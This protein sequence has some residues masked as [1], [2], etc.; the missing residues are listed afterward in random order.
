MFL[1]CVIPYHINPTKYHFKS[2]ASIVVPTYVILMIVLI[3][4]LCLLKQDCG[5]TKA[6]LYLTRAFHPYHPGVRMAWLQWGRDSL[7]PPPS[8]P[9]IMALALPL[10]PHTPETLET[11]VLGESA[12]HSSDV[13]VEGRELDLEGFERQESESEKSRN[14]RQYRKGNG[15]PPSSSMQS[16]RSSMQGK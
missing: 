14:T 4:I 16:M 12:T 3:I 2:V 9:L 13:E 7:N 6:L 5:V 1:S 11:L 15:L 10:P 8:I